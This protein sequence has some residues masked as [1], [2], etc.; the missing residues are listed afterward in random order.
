MPGP[1][2]TATTAHVTAG[3]ASSRPAPRGG[4]GRSR[5]R[6]PLAVGVLGGDLLEQVGDPD[7]VRPAVEVE[8]GLDGRADVVGVDVAVP[9]PVAADDDDRVADLAPAL[10]E[11]R[12]CRASA[13][14]QRNITS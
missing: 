5:D 8:G 2:L 13:R 9:R 11:G 6:R 10:L 14:S 1:L 3:S 12:R 7:P 4:R